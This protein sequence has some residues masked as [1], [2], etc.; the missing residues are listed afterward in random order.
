MKTLQK[1]EL[2]KIVK[3]PIEFL[4]L[5]NNVEQFVMKCIKSKNIKIPKEH[6]SLFVRI[7]NLVDSM[8]R[9]WK[10]PKYQKCR[11]NINESTWGHNILKPIIDFIEY[12]L[13][14]EILIRWDAITKGPI[15]K[16]DIFG[17][18]KNES[19]DLE[20]ILGEISY[21]PL[22]ETKKHSI[23]DR[24]KLSKGAKDSFDSI[25]RTYSKSPNF[26]PTNLKIYLLHSHG[27]KLEFLI[28]DKKFIPMFRMR[29]LASIEIPFKKDSDL[30]ELIKVLHTFKTE[31]NDENS[32]GCEN[33][34]NYES[35]KD[36]EEYEGS[37]S[38]YGYEN[39]ES[40][41]N[42]ILTFN[43]PV[44]QKTKNDV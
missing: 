32:D 5:P 34:E 11:P 26:N 23:K 12:D 41:E 24:I 31:E 9:L 17:V 33:Y 20:F 16:Y 40:D 35:D 14:S 28:V 15:K 38:S 29:R 27:T 30:L 43:T 37:E 18:C 13:E 22:D 10:N 2:W 25:S 44:I 4:S 6:T 39:Y 1:K 21:G 8:L 36:A 42:N 19:Y 3:E 7:K